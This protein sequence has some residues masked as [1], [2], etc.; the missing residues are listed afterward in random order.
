MISPSDQPG[1]RPRDT[2]NHFGVGMRGE[3]IVVMMPPEGPLT[4][5]RAFNLGIW[6][7]ALSGASGADFIGALKDIAES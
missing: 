2:A 6:L 4:P 3:K 5:E 7:V 1:G